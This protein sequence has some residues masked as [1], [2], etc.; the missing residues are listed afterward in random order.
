MKG[1]VF[2]NFLFKEYDAI[3]NYE[4]FMILIIILIFFSQV[5]LFW[6]QQNM[7]QMETIFLMKDGTQAIKSLAGCGQHEDELEALEQY[8]YDIEEADRHW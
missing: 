6:K 8:P 4:N 5:V 1:T 3:H 2:W 7:Q